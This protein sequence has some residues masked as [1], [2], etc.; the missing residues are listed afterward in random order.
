ME[1][2]PYV[3]VTAKSHTVDNP[4]GCIYIKR[5]TIDEID[6]SIWEKEMECASVN[7]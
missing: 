2:G 4:L 5:S 7:V 6:Y 1:F 3:E